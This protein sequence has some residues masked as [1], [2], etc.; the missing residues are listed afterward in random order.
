MAI[1]TR[2]GD[3]GET[4]LRDMSQVSKSSNRIE[5]YGTVDEAKALLGMIHPTGYEDLDDLF[6]SI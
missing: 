3:N 4:D 1:Y 6:E 2:R 5:A